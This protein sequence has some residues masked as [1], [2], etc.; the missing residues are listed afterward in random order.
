MCDFYGV[1]TCFCWDDDRLVI[2]TY[3][4]ENS[5]RTGDTRILPTPAPVRKVQSFDSRAFVICAPQGAYKLSRSGEFAVLSKNALGMG[6]EFFQV[7]IAW[8]NAVYLDNKQDKSSTPLFPL[9]ANA[10]VCTYPLNLASTELQ[11]ASCLAAGWETENNLCVIAHHRWLYALRSDVVQLI[12]TSDV[13]IVDILPVKRQDKTAG[14]LL[15]TERTYDVILVHGRDDKL[16]FERIHLRETVEDRAVLC[17]A[18]SL[19]ME[20]ILWLICCDR[21][22][23]YYLRK[24][25]FV[26]AVQEARVEERSF[27]CMQYYKPNVILGLSRGRELVELSLE[28]LEDSLSIDNNIILHTKMFEKTDIIMEKI[29]S[30]AKE[31]NALYESLTDEQDM[32]KRINLYATKQKLQ[33]NPCIEVS[34]LCKHCYLG[35]NI[36]EKLPKNSYLVF[37]FV[38]K[39]RSTVCVKKATETA[40]AIKMPVNNNRI[41]CSSSI[42]MDLITLIKEQHPW[43]LIQNFVNFQHD[44]KRKRGK[45]KKDKT[46]FIDAKIASLQQLIAE[47]R[48]L[49]MIK[50]CEIKRSVRAE[51]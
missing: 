7:L 2:F 8:N 10:T 11:L 15:L 50:L 12:Y 6:G 21:F 37:T 14:L 24:E 39:N 47:K 42:N 17:V 33:I 26:D 51:L 20:N 25:L 18:F 23:T 19:R 5:T 31:L 3:T 40:I 46:A 38:S 13:A 27:T 35:L 32:L 9:T 22:R 43:C 44:L 29:C 48:E 28:E 34:R 16:A 30:K 4:K 45:P 36:S 41:L 1:E 49:N